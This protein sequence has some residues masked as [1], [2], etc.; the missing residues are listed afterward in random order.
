M[1]DIFVPSLIM[2]IF[3]NISL[4]QRA[5]EKNGMNFNRKHLK[6]KT[7]ERMKNAYGF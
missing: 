2:N 5:T 1:L 4:T 6:Q 3:L 7:K